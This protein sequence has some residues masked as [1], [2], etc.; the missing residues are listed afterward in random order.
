[1]TVSSETSIS[2][3]NYNT[4]QSRVER[5]L[6]VGTGQ[7]GYGQTPVSFPVRPLNLNESPLP[8]EMRVRAE[9][10][11]NLLTDINRIAIHQ[12]GSESDLQPIVQGEFVKADGTSVNDKDGFNNYIN[13][14]DRLE[15]DPSRVDGTQLTIETVDSDSRFAAW[16]G[17]L[18]H[19]FTLTFTDDD[20]RRAFFNAGGQVWISAQIEGTTNTKGDDWKTMLN[21][22]G[23]VYFKST[24]AQRSPDSS[25][26][27]LFP[28][29]DAFGN[30]TLT[31][32]LQT[33][34][35]REGQSAE[36]AENRYY[37]YAKEISNRAIQFTIQFQ[38][39]DLGDPNVDEQVD[40]TVVSIVRLRRPTGDY[41]S[42]AAPSY[43]K[44]SSLSLGD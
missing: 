26:G 14:V 28:D 43:S 13:E 24:T 19:S 15:D 38:D 33:L 39:Q 20:H 34:F 22:M 31:E 10:M 9:H 41:V 32:S 11:N 30:F 37:I 12:F 21:N 1:M 5:L 42:V 18:S 40:G 25:G 7:I 4:L 23:T 35:L 6:A 8:A 36:Y 27:T 44:Q 17:Q 29:G 2:A 3:A 16:N